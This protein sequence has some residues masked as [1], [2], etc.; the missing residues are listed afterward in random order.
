M[1]L[2]HYKINSKE[3]VEKKKEKKPTINKKSRELFLVEKSTW[4][5]FIDHSSPFMDA[6]SE[7]LILF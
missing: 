4:Y 3:L 1:T 6:K 5:N 7:M 2:T